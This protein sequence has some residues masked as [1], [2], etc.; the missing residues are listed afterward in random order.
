M[1]NHSRH[2]MRGTRAPVVI[3]LAFAGCGS[4]HGTADVSGTVTYK[5][6]PVADAT[7]N[8]LPKSDKPEAKSAS[9]RTDGSGRFTLTTYF[10]PDEQPA[11][12]LPGEY[13]VTITKIDEPQGMFDPHKD[14]PPKN[15][16]PLQYGTPQKSPHAAEVKSSGRNHFDFKLAD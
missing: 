8:F 13:A 2:V 4:S 12:A 3:L 15:H 1:I 6:Q 11:G 14:P 5:E 16:L 7:V 10:G 9:G